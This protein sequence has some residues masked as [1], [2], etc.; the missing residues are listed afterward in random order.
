[1]MTWLKDV[2]DKIKEFE[3]KVT[4]MYLDSKGLV[5]VGVGSLL[6]NPDMAARLP[7]VNRSTGEPAAQDAIRKEW[8]DLK[9]MEQNNYAAGFFKRHTELDLPEE[10]IDAVLQHHLEE[11]LTGLRREFTN[12]DDAP[13]PARKAL[14]DMAFNLGL[15]G[16]VRKFPSFARGFRG[17][18]WAVCARE[19]HRRGISEVRNRYVEDLFKQLA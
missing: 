4:H 16:V 7:F 5:T 2:V 10:A 15:G 1:M 14:L 8:E 11:F 12:F 18:E 19:C 9:A 13:E 17:G 6:S 3:G